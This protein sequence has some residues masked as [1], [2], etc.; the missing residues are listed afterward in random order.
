MKPVHVRAIIKR[1]DLFEEGLRKLVAEGIEDG[2]I[3]PCNPKL[4]VFMAMGALNW[5]RK[6]YR[7]NGDWSGPQ[8]ARTLTEMLER[9]LSSAPSPALA[10]DPAKV[11][12]DE[13]APAKPKARAPRR[14]A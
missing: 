13:P 7:P 9:A 11:E 14:P 4:A 6:W 12:L 3:V 1:R 8:I 5:G 2:S 10:T